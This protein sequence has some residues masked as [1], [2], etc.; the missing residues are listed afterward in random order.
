M[1]Q[2]HTRGQ[3]RSLTFAGLLFSCCCCG[4]DDEHSA[5]RPSWLQ[6]VRRSNPSADSLDGN[7]Q[8]WWRKGWNS[9]RRA[10]EWSKSVIDDT[11]SCC[12]GPKWKHFV[13]R[14]KRDGKRMYSSKPSRFQYDP[15]SYQLNFDNGSRRVEDYQVQGF[16][17]SAVKPGESARTQF[18]KP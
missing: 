17:L 11:G 12:S 16:S 14:F 2:S 10:G 3:A 7:S 8:K 1:D 5:L 15:L 6:K 4:S 9:I 13:R 18:M